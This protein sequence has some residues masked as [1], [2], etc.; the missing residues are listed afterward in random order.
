MSTCVSG[1]FSSNC[2]EIAFIKSRNTVVFDDMLHE[3]DTGGGFSFGAHA[4]HLNN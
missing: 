3:I 1:H 4:F 2:D